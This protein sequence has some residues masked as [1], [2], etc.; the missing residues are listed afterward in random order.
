VTRLGI[1]PAACIA[2]LDDR[3]KRY[4]RYHALEVFKASPMP[5]GR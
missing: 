2:R 4:L 1:N 5:A 3:H